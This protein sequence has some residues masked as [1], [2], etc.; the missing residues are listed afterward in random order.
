MSDIE[1]KPESI[2]ARNRKRRDAIKGAAK[3]LDAKGKALV[4]RMV[5][6]GSTLLEVV[7]RDGIGSYGAV[8][9]AVDADPEFAAALHKASAKGAAALLEE[10]QQLAADAADAGDQDAIRA[11]DM[12]M[13]CT[14]S[15]VEKVAPR[16]YGQLVKLAGDAAQSAITVQV[17]SF[18]NAKKAETGDNA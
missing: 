4:L 6:E 7:R 10:A 13:R 8:W 17:V 5:N 16:E 11:A 3:A 18:A 9:A 12:Y 1:T 2:I 15:F 14:Q